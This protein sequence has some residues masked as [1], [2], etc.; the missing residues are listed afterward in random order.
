MR[1]RKEGTYEEE[2]GDV[3]GR[4]KE[5]CREEGKLRERQE[6]VEKRWEA[7]VTATKIRGSPI[8]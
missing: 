8:C 2:R 4:R 6:E 1:E 3:K 5:K 7:N